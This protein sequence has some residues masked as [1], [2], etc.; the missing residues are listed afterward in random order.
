LQL[1]RLGTF[2]ISEFFFPC[3]GKNQCTCF[4]IDE[5]FTLYEFI[6]V[7]EIRDFYRYHNSSHFFTQYLDGFC[8]LFFQYNV[9]IHSKIIMDQFIP[10]ASKTSPGY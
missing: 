8:N 2:E 7:E 5:H 4:G 1:Y 10:H 9:E 3:L 6:F